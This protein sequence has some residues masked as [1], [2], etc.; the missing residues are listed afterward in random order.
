LAV[1]TVDSSERTLFSGRV[2]TQLA[3]LSDCV[4]P[5]PLEDDN[6]I[7]LFNFDASLPEQAYR[8]PYEPKWRLGFLGCAAIALEAE[9]FLKIFG[10]LID[11]HLQ[12]GFELT[13]PFD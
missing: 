9:V 2:R 3:K 8:V 11:R 12:E 4:T 6:I 7:T 10:H 5:R 13:S 1:T